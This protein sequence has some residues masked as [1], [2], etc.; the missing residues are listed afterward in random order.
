VDVSGQLHASAALPSGKETGHLSKRRLRWTPQ[1]VWTVW[2]TEKFLAPAGKGTPDG[3]ARSLV[4]L[5]TENLEM[6]VWSILN[7]CCVTVIFATWFLWNVFKIKQIILSS[8]STLPSPTEKFWVRP[9]PKILRNYSSHIS[10]VTQMP[11]AVPTQ[12]CYGRRWRNMAEVW[13][14]GRLRLKCDGTRAETTFRLSAKRTSPFKSAGGVSSVDY[15]KPSC[16][17]QR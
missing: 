7:E 3:A 12:H 16:A 17:L 14:G 13:E 8:G 9:C 10:A 15:W 1:L 5:P 11:S 2:R 6:R 4:T